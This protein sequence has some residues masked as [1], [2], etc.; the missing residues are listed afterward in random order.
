MMIQRQSKFDIWKYVNK[1]TEKDRPYPGHMFSRS[2]PHTAKQVPSRLTSR[3]GEMSEKET[4]LLL[5]EVG[6]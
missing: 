1:K 5:A 6:W 3:S 2:L 4:N